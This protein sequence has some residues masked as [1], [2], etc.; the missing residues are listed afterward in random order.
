MILN[1]NNHIPNV[2]GLGAIAIGV[3]GA[4]AV[5]ALIDAPWE[6]KAPKLLSVRPERELS[7]WTYPRDVIL[8][9]AGRLIIRGGTVYISLI[10][11][12]RE[13]MY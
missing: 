9:L 3:V 11:V 13:W 2:R 8:Y 1:R 4:N 12:D 10:T 5:D 6:L 7:K